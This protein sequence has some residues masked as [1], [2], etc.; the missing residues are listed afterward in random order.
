MRPLKIAIFHGQRDRSLLVRCHQPI[1]WLERLGA[2]EIL[3]VLKAWEADVALL[4]NYWEPEAMGILRS[5]QRNGI[6]VVANVDRDLFD[7]QDRESP[8]RTR[9]ICEAVDAVFVPNRPL[10]SCLSR[11]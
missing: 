8:P 11:V 2:I 6:R 7:G 10:A 4:H 1:G 9:Q 3:P 5:L